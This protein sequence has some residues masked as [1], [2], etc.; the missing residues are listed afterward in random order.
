MGALGLV[1]RPCHLKE[2]RR[3]HGRKLGGGG[4]FV[5]W[6]LSCGESQEVRN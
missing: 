5:A 2:R 3:R 1:R 6:L 4:V